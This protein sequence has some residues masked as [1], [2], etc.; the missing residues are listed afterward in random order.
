MHRDPDA[1]SHFC[2]GGQWTFIVDHC[3][4]ITTPLWRRGGSAVV[5]VHPPAVS[6]RLLLNRYVVLVAVNV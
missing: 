3:L 6:M 2:F 1:A 4:I 5:G